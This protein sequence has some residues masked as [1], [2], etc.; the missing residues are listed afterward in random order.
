MI[1]AILNVGPRLVALGAVGGL[2]WLLGELD[3]R[4]VR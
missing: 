1:D 3:R 4:R 2:V